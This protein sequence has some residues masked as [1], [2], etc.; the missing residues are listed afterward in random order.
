MP[1]DVATVVV[2]EV[3]GAVEASAV[4]LA[5]IHEGRVTGTLAR[6]D[7]D[8]SAAS[9]SI[10]VLLDDDTL[11]GRLLRSRRSVLLGSLDASESPSVSDGEGTVGP[12]TFLLVP[13]IAGRR[14]N[15]LLVATWDEARRL[16]AE[17]R[18]IVEALAGQAAQALDRARHFESEQTIAETLQRSVLPVSLPRI[19]GVQLAARY[20]PGSAQLDVGGDWFDA[21]QVPDGKLGLVVGDVV[22]KGVQAAASMGQLRNAIRAYSVERL[23]PPS[24]LTRLSR[25]ADDVLDTS[26]ATVVYLVIDPDKGVC[27]MSSAG[28]PPPLVAYP[29]GRV[30]LLENARGL[31]LGT[32]IPTKYRQETFEL[33]AGSVLVLY[34]DGLVERRGRSIDDGLRDLQVA[35]LDAPKDPDRLLEHILEHVV[36]TGERGDDIAMLAVRVLP[37]AP[38]P[39]ELRIAARVESMD[40]VRDAMRA[41]LE[42]VPFARSHAEAVVLATWEAC[43]NAIEHAVE[44]TDNSVSIRAVLEDSLVR[45]VVEDTGRWAPPSEREDRGLGLRLIGSLMSSVHVAQDENGTTITLEKAFAEEPTGS[46]ERG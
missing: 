16:A 7:E 34:T 37:V 13:L 14:T 43:A 9:D 6:H 22:G 38:R 8:G 30:H 3:A 25:L 39:L 36:G 35:V 29:D 23:R 15:G 32:G 21:F 18:A 28:H 41:W 45:V 5:A 11:D 26:F 31:P 40:L 2:D 46:T 24:A 10:D 4:A 33:P 44:A 1:A 19:E 27:R 17:D 12:G 20:L 42:G